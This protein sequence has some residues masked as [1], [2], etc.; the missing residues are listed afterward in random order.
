MNHATQE[1]IRVINAELNF[2]I[3]VLQRKVRENKCEL[4]MVL[5]IANRYRIGLFLIHQI[6]FALRL[7]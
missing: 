4:E 2:Q 5:F 1:S 7:F 3:E 6:K